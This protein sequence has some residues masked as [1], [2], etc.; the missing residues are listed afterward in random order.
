[1]GKASR[2]LSGSLLLLREEIQSL[3][4]LLDCTALSNFVQRLVLLMDVVVVFVVDVHIS[5]L[6]ISKT[7]KQLVFFL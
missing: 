1:M 7:C 6:N 3:N 2:C 5:A 4:A